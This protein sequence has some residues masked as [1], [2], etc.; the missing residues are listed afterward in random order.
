MT[1]L[2][3]TTL[4]IYLYN[5]ESLDYYQN[6]VIFA[7]TVEHV[8]LSVG[9]FFT[10]D[11]SRIVNLTGERLPTRQVQKK[12]NLKFLEKIKNLKHLNLSEA[13]LFNIP[14][15]QLSKTLEEIRIEYEVDPVPNYS[16]LTKYPNLKSLILKEVD[17]EENIK[18]G[19]LPISLEFLHLNTNLTITDENC[20]FLEDLENLKNLDYYSDLKNIHK[21]KFP[22]SINYLQLRETNDNYRCIIDLS[23]INKMV[24]LKTLN[25]GYMKHTN[26]ESLTSFPESLEN[27]YCMHCNI[28]DYSFLKYSNIK[29]LN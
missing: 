25:I 12:P 28:K 21:I 4:E 1:T 27:L 17:F 22:K 7:D 3:E 5:Q 29:R 13:R 11:P 19:D 23:F 6:K 16:F 10:Y 9:Y 8:V 15:L 14:D 20:N 26:I 2:S 18:K 24:N